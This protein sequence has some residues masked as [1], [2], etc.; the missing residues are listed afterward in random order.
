MQECCQTC[1]NS[2]QNL[3]S[4]HSEPAI[5]AKLLEKIHIPH[6]HCACTVPHQVVGRSICQ[7]PCEHN[8]W[9]PHEATWKSAS[10]PS[11]WTVWRSWLCRSTLLTVSQEMM[12]SQKPGI[13]RTT[14]SGASNPLSALRH[15][16][17]WPCSNICPKKPKTW[18]ISQE[19]V[20]NSRLLVPSMQKCAQR[21]TKLHEFLNPNHQIA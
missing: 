17:R 9:L 15:D 1:R 13:T 5:F 10:E 21:H 3:E 20:A 8:S 7:G 4:K 6:Q 2:T 19:V 16:I 14:A 18:I 12:M 11:F